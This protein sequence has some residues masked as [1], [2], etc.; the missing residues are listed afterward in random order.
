M[1]WFKKVKEGR[2]EP[3]VSEFL[4]TFFKLPLFQSRMRALLG[5]ILVEDFVDTYNNLTLKTVFTLKYAS[6]LVNLKYLF[7]S[8]DNC[9]LNLQV[10][11]LGWFKNT[12]ST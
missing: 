6:S 4:S 12:P 3:T 11:L 10:Y 1:I 9:Y 2:F 5:D 7:K 8:D